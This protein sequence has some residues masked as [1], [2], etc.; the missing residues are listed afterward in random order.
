[1]VLSLLDVIVQ[2]H[3]YTSIIDYRVHK[4]RPPHMADM[5]FPDH[6]LCYLHQV[7]LYHQLSQVCTTSQWPSRLRLAWKRQH[8]AAK[9]CYNARD[10]GRAMLGVLEDDDLALATTS[11]MVAPEFGDEHLAS[12]IAIAVHQ[13][14]RTNSKLSCGS[15]LMLC[16][17]VACG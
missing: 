3:K 17:E 12:A 16:L 14:K 10:S 1:M 15:G 5:E 7:H 8:Q 13:E 11:M 2:L 4:L 9:V 6:P